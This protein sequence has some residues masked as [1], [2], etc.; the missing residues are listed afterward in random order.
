M[1]PPEPIYPCYLPVLGEFNRMTPHEGPSTS[2]P[3][4]G[5]GFE[6]ARRAVDKARRR[7]A[8]LLI[9]SGLAGKPR[10][11][12]EVRR[13]GCG[14]GA[15][16]VVGSGWTPKMCPARFTRTCSPCSRPGGLRME[17]EAAGAQVLQVLPCGSNGAQLRVDGTPR[18]S[19]QRAKILLRDARRCPG[20]HELLRGRR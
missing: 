7:L 19:T 6:S 12:G 13:K 11:A 5:L 9:L 17:A 15:G 8:G 1:H 18:N 14:Y 16:W 4:L 20:Q 3:E 10:T 2:L